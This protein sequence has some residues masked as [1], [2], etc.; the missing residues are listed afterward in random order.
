MYTLVITDE[1]IDFFWFFMACVQAL[2]GCI[3]CIYGI[4]EEWKE[5]IGAVIFC[6][7]CGLFLIVMGI[8]FVLLLP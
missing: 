5:S 4:D 6:L 8:K 2:F 1:F 3:V 7:A